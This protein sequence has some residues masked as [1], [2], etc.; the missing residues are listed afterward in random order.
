[1]VSSKANQ[2]GI[3]SIAGQRLNPAELKIDL[4]C[5]GVRIGRSCRIQEEGRPICSRP[6]HLASGLELILP[7]ELRELW[8]NAPVN[9]KF[10]ERTP[11]RLIG[12]QGEYRLFDER[13]DLS[14]HVKLAPKPGWC[15]LCTTSGIPMSRIGMLNGTFLSIELGGAIYFDAAKHAPDRQYC[16][17]AGREAAEIEKTSVEDIVETV[18]AAQK[19]SGITFALL[20]G[21]YKDAGGLTRLFPYLKALKQKVGILVGVQFPPETELGLYDQARFLG[22]D[23][24]SFCL[25]FFNKDYFDRYAPDT[26]LFPGQKQI[27]GALEYCVRLMGKGRVSGEIVA[28]V[29]PIED[30]LRAVDYLA[31]VGAIP[32]VRIFRPLRGTDMENDAPPDPSEMIRVFRHVYQ[33]S[34]SHH[35]PIGMAPN[36]HF[37]VLPHPEDTLYLA[38]DAQEGYDY[39]RWIF[40]MEQVMRPYFLRRMRRHGALRA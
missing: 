12:A 32:R 29:E 24:F 25:E 33:A 38:S 8:V 3:D 6:G 22:A 27:F 11:Y 17:P 23:Q 1:M 7:G 16:R 4:L 26:S 2:A 5:R 34:R 10:V 30:T 15:D 36:I 39:Q 20:C 37:S 21:G 31:G 14:Y 35:L 18:S 9:E 13:H 19:E 28:G 40:T